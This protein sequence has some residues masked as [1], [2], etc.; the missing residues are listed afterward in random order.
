ME[1]ELVEERSFL[2]DDNIETIYFGGGTPSLVDPVRIGRFIELVAK[3]YFVAG[4]K[5]ITIEVNPDDLTLQYLTSLRSVGVNRLSIGVQSFNDEELRFMNRRHNGQSAK[6]AVRMAREAGFEN[7]TIDLIFGVDGFPESILRESLATAVELSVE[8]IS[9]YHLTI[10]SGTPFARKVDRGEL[11][12]V[13]DEVSEAEYKIVEQV[14]TDAGY[15]HY[16][17][18]NY[19]REGYRSRHNSS[20]WHDVHY[21]GIGAGAHSFNG[22]QRRAVCSS[23]EGYLSSDRSSRYEVELLSEQ[24]HY[25]ECVMTSLRCREGIDLL[26]FS[27]R[28]DRQ[29]H[30]HLLEMS[31]PWIESGKLIC[32]GSSLRIPTS[33][34]LISDLIIESLFL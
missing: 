30:E 24:D 4:L 7:I 20:Y 17:V 23:I 19:A 32:S 9:V 26:R 31:K 14:L 15:D 6:D 11:R 28:F 5:E 3:N 16:E 33:E 21:L 10:E 34:F 2:A 29:Y 1:R 27:E 12:V 22:V 8:H 25:N 13:A 18:S